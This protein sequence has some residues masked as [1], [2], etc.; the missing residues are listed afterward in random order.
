[1]GH[2]LRI[3]SDVL[4]V[5]AMTMTHSYVLHPGEE[6]VVRCRYFVVPTQKHHNPKVLVDGFTI[7]TSE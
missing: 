6:F 3:S 5:V 1:M 2:N 4:A 7:G